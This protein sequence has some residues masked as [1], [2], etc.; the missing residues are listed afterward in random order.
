M[1]KPA[2]VVFLVVVLSVS[3]VAGFSARTLAISNGGMKITAVASGDC[4]KSPSEIIVTDATA[5][6]SILITITPP[7]KYLDVALLVPLSRTSFSYPTWTV[8]DGK[9]QV[10]KSGKGKI[11][12]LKSAGGCVITGGS[13]RVVAQVT[14]AKS[15]SGSFTAAASSKQI[16]VTFQQTAPVDACARTISN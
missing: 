12:V 10:A 8:A 11:E 1:K 14:N 6:C 16:T 3:F 2:V 13:T 15:F 5:S 4:A 9:V 7:K